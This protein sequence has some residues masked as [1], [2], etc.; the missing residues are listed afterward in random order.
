MNKAISSYMRDMQRRSADSRWGGLSAAAR[1]KKMSDLAK[2]RWAKRPKA[3][4]GND[5]L[6]HEA[7]A[8]DV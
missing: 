3:K 5:K 8:K 4:S 7:G 2:A 1:K 6:T